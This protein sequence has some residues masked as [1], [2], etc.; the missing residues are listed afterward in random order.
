[1]KDKKP[2][3]KILFKVHG[4]V[5]AEELSD[6]YLNQIDEKKWIIAS[7]CECT[8]D[9]VDVERVEPVQ[10]LSD[11]DVTNDGIVNFKDLWFKP[12]TGVLMNVDMDTFL[13]KIIK[14]EDTLDCFDLC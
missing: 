5:V 14:G 7:E 8:Y 6:L 2:R 11:Y 10:E 9:D 12:V 3:V 4:K 13:D 1:M